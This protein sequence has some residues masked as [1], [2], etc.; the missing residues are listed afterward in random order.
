MELDIMFLIIG[1]VV[2]ALIAIVLIN[3]KKLKKTNVLNKENLIYG[4]IV[5]F[6]LHSTQY[7]NYPYD[8][9]PLGIGLVALLLLTR[10]AANHDR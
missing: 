5:L 2:F 9:L 1:L 10:C 3:K 6:S 8:L 7:V 4:A